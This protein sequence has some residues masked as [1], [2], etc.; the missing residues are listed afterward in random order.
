MKDNIIIAIVGFSCAGKDTLAEFLEAN[1]DLNFASL[2]TSREPRGGES[3]GKPHFFVTKEKIMEMDRNKEFLSFQGY[4]TKFKGIEDMAYYGL[5][6]NSLCSNKAYVLPIGFNTIDELRT[7][8]GTRVKVIFVKADDETRTER[9]K[10]RKGY[11]PIEWKNRLHSDKTK[12]PEGTIC[13]QVN[14]IIKNDKL[15]DAKRDLLDLL[16]HL[17]KD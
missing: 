1:T 10:L 13:P 14:H 16:K 17:R 8:L 15:S 12:Y 9:A 6:K 2:H 5:S 4:L 7:S 11:D 3:N